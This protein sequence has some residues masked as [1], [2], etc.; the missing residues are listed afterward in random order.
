[1]R[2]AKSS[3]TIRRGDA[4]MMVAGGTEAGVYEADRR[5]LRV[6]ARALDA[7]RRPGARLAPVRHRPRRLRHRARVPA[8]SSSRRSSTPRPAA[9]RSS[10]SWSATARPRMPRTSRCRRPGG[11]GAVRAAD[12]ALAKAGLSRR[13]TSTTSTPTRPRRP[14]ATRPSSRRSRRSSASAPG[15][16]DHG[17]Q[18]RCSAI[19]WAPP[20]RSRRSSR[21]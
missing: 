19:P 3:E 5:R 12:R 10:P 15:G 14:R 1:M 4:D 6:D 20:A 7:Q 8:S 13:R 2:S 17:Q 16:V 18:D 9:R 21:S 11:I